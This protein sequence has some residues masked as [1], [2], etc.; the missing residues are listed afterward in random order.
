MLTI[1]PSGRACEYLDHPECY[2][3]AENNN[4]L[5]DWW[6]SGPYLMPRAYVSKRCEHGRLLGLLEVS[7]SPGGTTMSYWA[8]ITFT[9]ERH[10]SWRKN[11]KWMLSGPDTEPY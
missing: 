1:S 3:V 7:Q 2:T 6:T 8:D 4:E 10:P 11:S 9:L 5:I